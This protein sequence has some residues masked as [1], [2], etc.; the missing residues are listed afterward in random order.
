M[1]V[2]R[3]IVCQ[4]CIIKRFR[5]GRPKAA[6]K[7]TSLLREDPF[8]NLIKRNNA[9]ARYRYVYSTDCRLRPPSACQ[10]R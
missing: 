6:K 9:R 7:R 3:L 8:F 10:L 4:H 2:T 1:I 5:A